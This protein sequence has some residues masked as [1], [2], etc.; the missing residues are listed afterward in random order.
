MFGS[1][2]EKHK[3]ANKLLTSLT[4]TSLEAC[5]IT[6]FERIQV[7]AMTSKKTHSNYADF[8][9]LSSK[10]LK[11]ELFKGFWPYFTRQ[12]ISWTM[13]LQSDTFF[14]TQIRSWYKIP[15]DE[16]ISGSRL[17]LCTLL[18]SSTT[19]AAA[20]PFDSVKTHLE[21]HYNDLQA[22]GKN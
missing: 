9:K 12:V 7:F 18:V 4:I 11:A 16:M 22:S 3:Y 19:I 6:P 8:Y 1:T 14:K 17:A 5:L 13:W 21:K 10:N 20:M 15:D 2:Y